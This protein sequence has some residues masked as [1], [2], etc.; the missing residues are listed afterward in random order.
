MA[1]R[2]LISLVPVVVFAFACSKQGEGE[3]CNLALNANQDCGDNLTCQLPNDSAHACNETD[4]TVPGEG[5]NCLPHRC[6]YPAPQLPTDDRCIGYSVAAPSAGTGGATAV[7]SGTGG[8]SS[9]AGA[10]AGGSTSTG[11]TST[12]GGTVSNGGSTDAG[13]TASDNGGT[14]ASGT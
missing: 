12:A 14:S 4:P 7:V 1:I 9:A 8:D 11:G 13:G 10:S 6:C 5:F 3:R 2:K